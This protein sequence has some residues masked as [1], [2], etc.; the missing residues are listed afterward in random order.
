MISTV[1]LDDYVIGKDLCVACGACEGMCPYWHSM[2]GKLM[3]DFECSREEGRCVSF[4]PRMPTDLAA[5]RDRFFDPSSVAGE[6][7]PFR[8]LCLTRAA[9]P[10]IRAGSQHGG[11]VTALTELA[12]AEGFIDAAV[13]SKASGGLSPAG[14]LAVTAE[15][16]RAC[17]G[18]S[19]QIPATLSV[20]NEAL[21][22]GR[23]RKI[24]VVGT[25]CKTLAVYKMKSEPVPDRD[26]HADHI[27]MVIGLFCGWGLDWDGLA[28]LIGQ[29]ADPASIRRIDIPPSR[30]H[31]MTLEGESGKTEIDL[32]E[33]TPLV[34][35]SCRFCTDMTAEFADISV[36]GARSGDGW[37]VDK[38]WNQTIIRTEQGKRLLEKARTK[39]VLEFKEAPPGALAKLKGASLSKKRSG[40]R[41]IRAL[42]GRPGDLSY[43]TPSAG[44]FAGL[45]GEAEDQIE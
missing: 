33:V 34:R 20:L 37:E 31:C 15:E 18:S 16:A 43:L 38:G 44:L 45:T 42:T 4:C 13:L 1:A 27:G 9:D 21:K 12:L 8:G 32:D 25:P 24:G 36:G 22:E 40:V 19:F 35:K 30:Y 17:R 6:L 11:T 28:A 39:G 29:R 26:Y 10:A 3:H 41:N 23:Y 5:L 14:V 7:G 2:R